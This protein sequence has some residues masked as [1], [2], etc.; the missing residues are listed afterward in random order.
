VRRLNRL[1]SNGRFRTLRKELRERGPAAAQHH[2]DA[3]ED[4]YQGRDRGD[5]GTITSRPSSSES[6]NDGFS[7]WPSIQVRSTGPSGGCATSF[8][9]MGDEATRRR[10]WARSMVG[11]P[12]RRPYGPPCSA[13]A[14][15]TPGIRGV[16][17][18]R[19]KALEG[20][21]Y[22]VTVGSAPETF[23]RDNGASFKL[24][25]HDHIVARA[26][27]AII[28]QSLACRS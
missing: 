1:K 17:K 15:P 3:R 22:P 28:S 10:Y 8:S 23:E 18:P 13:M 6:P 16:E 7:R 2:R 11:P 25:C 27:R 20:C 5:T 4:N 21:C 19:R 9:M 26:S 14:L 12:Q 24:P